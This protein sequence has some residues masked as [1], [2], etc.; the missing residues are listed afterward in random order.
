M[1]GR[2][3]KLSDERKA[4]LDACVADGWPIRQMTETHGFNFSTIKKHHPGY[5][6]MS[7]SEAGKLG[8]TQ[9]E[10]NRRYAHCPTMPA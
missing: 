3:R 8:T 9:K 7:H 6:G 4:L 1:K 10:I 2:G 5:T